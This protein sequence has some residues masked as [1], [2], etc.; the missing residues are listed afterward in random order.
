M[1]VLGKY[2]C[3]RRHLEDGYGSYNMLSN[4]YNCNYTNKRNNET[5]VVSE[6]F[7]CVYVGP[8]KQRF[9]IKIQLANHPLF[10]NLLE[11][12]ADEY[13][14]RS[15]GP[16][17]L[18][19]DVDAFCDALAEMEIQDSVLPHPIVKRN[20]KK[21]L[22]KYCCRRRH[23]E[24]VCGSYNML[25][26]NYNYNYSNKR[27]RNKVVP[28]GFFCVYVGSNKQRFT[29]RIQLAN[30]PL[31][32]NLLEDAADEFGFRSDGPLC[33]PCDVDFFCDALAEMEIPHD[34]VFS[35]PTDFLEL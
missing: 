35:H 21:V 33:L 31:F 11:D 27:N 4:N 22:G 14:L 29:I 34:S 1:K 2:C 30:H 7:F 18:P 32:Q 6:G 17:C 15:D 16:L 28:Q 9:M 10:Q 20:C 24:D 19:C 25:S 12:A 3:R 8:E 26:N 23:L 5:K 13:G